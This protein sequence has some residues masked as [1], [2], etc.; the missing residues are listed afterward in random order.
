MASVLGVYLSGFSKS[1]G[2]IT[3]H[4][5]SS[6]TGLGLA[7]LVESSPLE[8]QRCPQLQKVLSQCYPITQQ[9]MTVEE[10]TKNM[11]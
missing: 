5:A 4:L 9:T 1:Q 8:T 10:L 2:T 3:W 11:T 6:S 7:R